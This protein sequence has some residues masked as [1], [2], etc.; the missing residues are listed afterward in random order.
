MIQGMLLIM[1]TILWRYFCSA[2]Q[3]LA[4][5]WE[6]FWRMAQRIV[7]YYRHVDSNWIQFYSANQI[8]GILLQACGQCQAHLQRHSRHISHA[9]YVYQ[10]SHGSLKSGE[11]FLASGQKSLILTP[12]LGNPMPISCTA[13][14]MYDKERLMSTA[15]EALGHQSCRYH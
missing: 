3:I 13:C 2:N 15:T 6:S 14:A 5:T 11:L 7:D 1:G 10:V 8:I 12:V 4:Q 9:L